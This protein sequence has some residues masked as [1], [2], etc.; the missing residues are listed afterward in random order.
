M[1][2]IEAKNLTFTYCPGT[3]YERKALDNITFRVERG[4]I[5]GI[6]G[7]NGSGKST[8]IKHL[9]GILQPTEG[10]IKIFGKDI[11]NKQYKN[12]LWEKV[13]IVFQFP[14]QQ[15]FED[16]VF[17]EIAY[18]LKNLQVSKEVIPGR[19]KFSLEKVGLEYDSIRNLSP[20]CLSGGIR[21]RVAIASILAMEPEILILDEC[22]VGLDLLGREKIIDIIKKIKEESSTT[23]IMVSHNL[24]ELIE[25]CSH[26][27]VLKDGKLIFFGKTQD[28][29]NEKIVQQMYFNMFP[30]YIQLIYKLSERY[31]NV[32]V[33]SIDIAE[34][35]IELHSLLKGFKYEKN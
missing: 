24:S 31:E 30:D 14:E 22:T 13:G 15:L 6:I 35:E 10:K 8:F 19:I 32:N 29:L 9:N 5:V 18:G 33:R 17:N 27:A 12:E 2:V 25:L 21:R 20:L 26:I 1:P 23:I 28:V 34:I 7:E 3:T 11:S 16:T 4:D